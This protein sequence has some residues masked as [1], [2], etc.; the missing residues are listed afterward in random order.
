MDH[1]VIGPRLKDFANTSFSRGRSRVVEALWLLCQWALVSSWV[2][3]AVHRCWL[4]RLFGAKIGKRV[5]IKPG[6]RV[7]F[8][9]RLEVGDDSWLGEDVWIDN[10]DLVR[11][12]S[13]CCISQRC[14][15]CTGNHDWSRTTFDLITQPV[16][17]QD[18][19]WIASSSIIGPGVTVGRGA[20]LTLGSV[21]SKNLE[22]WTIYRGAP[23]QE[24]QKRVIRPQ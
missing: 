18:G 3:G 9:W 11:I 19:A 2:P 23:A 7:K 15:I 21:T 10:L 14:Y 24:V 17:I 16:Q 8:P 5:N 12:G 6:L 22:P 13:D 20:V 4:L 1:D